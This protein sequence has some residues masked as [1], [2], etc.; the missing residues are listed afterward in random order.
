MATRERRIRRTYEEIFTDGLRELSGEDQGLVNNL[1]LMTKLGWESD[2]YRRV[3]EQLQRQGLIISSRG[4]R[5]G[6][7]ALS[8]PTRASALNLFVSYSHA[9][10]GVKKQLEK[11]L[12][13]L[14]RMN[15]I[16]KWSD[17]QIR[18]G[19][20]WDRVISANLKAANI[21]VIMVS[22]D[23]LNSSY[24]YDIDMD[25]ALE[26][27]DKRKLVLIPVIVGHCLWNLA[28]FA[29]IQSLPK[30]A[31]PICSWPNQ[32]EALVNVADGIRVA[33]EGLLR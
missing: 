19:Q 17:R 7:I 4:G 22:V 28:P 5:G 14:E 12:H 26:Y 29:R 21:V 6:A 8:A 27:H 15:L 13:P 30:D 1:T 9:D 10:E 33:A 2:R 18:P 24:C 16:K 3:K 23:F 32:D 20:E 31:L 25:E 11:H